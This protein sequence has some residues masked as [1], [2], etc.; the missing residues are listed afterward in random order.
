MKKY[1]ILFAAMILIIVDIRIQIP[2]YFPA[3]EAFDTEAPQTVDLIINHVVRDRLT[4]DLA[5]DALGLL[6]LAI[7]SVLLIKEHRRYA[8]AA[9]WSAIALAAYIYMRVMP[10][11][12]NGSLRFRI[13]YVSYFVVLALEAVA[14]FSAMYAVCSQLESLE[15]HTYNNITIM[16]SMLTVATGAI[17]R[18]CWFYNMNILFMVYGILQLIAMGAYLF[19]VNKDRRI[20]EQVHGGVKVE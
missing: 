7:G 1:M 15:N 10:F 20:L 16:V 9:R 19:L 13:G 11:M 18:A 14:L 4:I 2:V 6:L 17:A 3:F 12:L 5:S 8:K